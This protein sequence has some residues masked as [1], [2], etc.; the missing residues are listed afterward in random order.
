MMRSAVV[1]LAVALLAGCSSSQVA[2]TPA[3]GIASPE[4]VAP[5]T[6]QPAMPEETEAP[7]PEPTPAA[8]QEADVQVIATHLFT[9]K[10]R[11]GGGTMQIVVEVTNK[12]AS[13]AKLGGGNSQTFSLLT[14]DGFVV[15]VGSLT[16]LPQYLAAGETGYLGGWTHLS[17][18]AT[19]A[20]VDSAEPSVTF[21][22]AETV[23]E[24]TLSVEKVTVRADE[25]DIWMEATGTV[26]NTGDADAGL[27]VIGV[28][29]LDAK[30]RPL[31]YLV[32]RLTAM[33]LLPQQKKGFSTNYPFASASLA[34]KVDSFKVYAYELDF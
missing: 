10:S 6:T 3:P 11:F 8:P 19:L 34:P 29:L 4:P 21:E 30:G 14:T 28:V 22:T 13:P 5:G 32:D 24:Q 16:P 15:E 2:G 25:Y 33:R 31:G 27:A 20:S 9:A 12:G 1:V 7:T 17:D 18:D 23:P 26:T